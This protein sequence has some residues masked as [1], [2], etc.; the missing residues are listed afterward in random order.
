MSVV[1]HTSCP[2]TQGTGPR[3]PM[4]TSMLRPFANEPSSLSPFPSA[5]EMARALRDSSRQ[6]RENIARLWLSEGLPAAFRGTPG[7]YESLRSWL[8]NR[9]GVNPKEITVVG[10]ARAGF[11]LASSQFGRPFGEHS[12]LDL[13]VVSTVLFAKVTADFERFALDFEAHDISARSERE[14][15]F[16]NENV[17]FGRRNIPKGFFDLKKLPSQPRYPVAKSVNSAMWELVR[18]LKITPDAP[19]VKSASIRAYRDWSAFVE[20]VSFNLDTVRRGFATPCR[21]TMS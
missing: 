20:R 1:L 14:D 18:R 3:V 8:G 9:I 19:T 21:T 17:A 10:S 15:M 16:W 4:D 5:D 2:Y 13:S 12:D 6:V 7:V 11:S